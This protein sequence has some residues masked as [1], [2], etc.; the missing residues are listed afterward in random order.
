MQ[1]INLTSSLKPRLVVGGTHFW[2][3]ADIYIAIP[4]RAPATSEENQEIQYLRGVETAFKYYP[5]RIEQGKIRPFAGF[6]I[7]PFYF[8]QDNN[9]FEYANG[10][11]LNHTDFPILTG[12]T[13]NHKNQL[14]ELGLAW[15]Y[16]NQQNYFISR[17]LEQVVHTPPLYFNFSYRLLLDTTLGAEKDWE[18]GL[19]QKATEILAERK[20]LSGFYLG[21]GFSSAFWLGQSSY[22]TTNRAYIKK[23]GISL[24]P[25]FNL[26]Y[27]FFQAD[28]NVSLAY[29][30]YGTFTN[31]YGA[32][33]SLNRSSFV[34]EG[35]K[36][37]FDYHG[38]VPF[39]GPALSYENL[40]FRESFEGSLVHDLSENKIAYGLTF[41]WDIRPDR[42]QSFILRT[43][44]RWFPAL[45]L[46]VGEQEEISFRNLEFNFIQLILYPNRIFRK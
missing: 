29:R 23:Y 17:N 35:T 45:G 5:W 18:S 22:N 16:N 36:S 3:H 34:L 15:N 2:G 12:F 10:P 32:V 9:F 38:F 28:M 30:K 25:D 33:Q 41:G 44:L 19:T 4:L 14:L 42:I 24:M 20:Q 1:R 7:A 8:E 21:A 37:L 31:T 13:F 27:H 11:E 40:S 39:V 43:N 46:E 6:S 26:G